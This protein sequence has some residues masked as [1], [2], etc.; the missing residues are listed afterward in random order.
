MKMIMLLMMMMIMK[1]V[2]SVSDN[3]PIMKKVK[4]QGC[5]MSLQEDSGSSHTLMNIAEFTKNFP[6]IK[7]Q[8]SEV[9][10][11]AYTGDKISVVGETILEVV[12]NGVEFQ[13]PIVVTEIGPTVIGRIWLN[14]FAQVD[15]LPGVHTVV[16]NSLYD[17]IVK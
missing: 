8:K 4:I 9:K 11:K 10:L 2:Y 13:L 6:A 14:A 5:E 16:E 15:S 12:E 17:D 7:L 1:R 3:K